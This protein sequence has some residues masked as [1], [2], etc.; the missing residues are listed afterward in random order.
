MF[1][2]TLLFTSI[3]ISTQAAA[4]NDQLQEVTIIGSAEDAMQ[5]PGSAHVVSE[6]ELEKFAYTDINRMVRQVPGVYLQ[7]EDGFGLRPNIGIRGS[8]SE[9]SDKITLLEDGVLMA[10]APYS[11]P[12][13][14]YFPTAG[15][16]HR[17]EILKGASI[18]RQGPATVGGVVNLISTPIPS[19][20]SAEINLETGDFSTHNLNASYGTRS[21]HWGMLLE[22]QQLQSDGFKKIDRSNQDSGF[23]VEDYLA[24]F[25]VNTAGDSSFYQQL[26][27]KI[28]YSEELSN[29]TYVGL[30]DR[31]FRDTSNRRYGLTA[32]DQMD[33]RHSSISARHLVQL[34]DQITLT[35][36][37]YQNR[38][39]RDW[40]KVDKIDGSSFGSLIDAA[41][42]GDVSA[43]SIL[44]GD[45]DAEISIK[46]NAREYTSQGL[47]SVAEWSVSSH[48]MELGI[49]Y[50]EDDVDRFQPSEV[51]QQ[52]SG[53]L[54]FDRITSPSS[55]NNRIEEA[56]ALAIHFMDTWQASAQLDVTMGLRHEDIDT[57]QLRYSDPQRSTRT[58]TANNSV[59]ETLWSL[60][61]TYDLTPNWQV[62]A[63]VHTGFAP[64]SA[65]SSDNVEPEKSQNY[66]AGFRYQSDAFNSSVI[67]FFSDYESTVLNCSQAFPCGQQSSGSQSLGQSEIAGV[68]LML[69]TRLYNSGS[70]Q[71]PLMV[72]F[73]HTDAEITD[74]ES[75]DSL[76]AGDVLR[77]VPENVLSTQVGINYGDSLSVYVNANYVSEMCHNNEC[78]RPGINDT[79]LETDETLIFDLVGHYNINDNTRLYIKID[80]I[81]DEQEIVARSPGGARPS[82]P[83]AASVGV[84][85]QF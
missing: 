33:T 70:V 71:V 82:K 6:A 80:N 7:E 12:A 29:E 57:R 34:N 19:Q 23:E 13:A 31:D 27:L 37:A 58:L 52:S 24:K 64:A 84:N 76:Q 53:N 4:S 10:P 8:G 17:I 74:A 60:G 72:S 43:Q 1:K 68:E 69:E 61:A 59:S 30:T 62:L 63:G 65:G 48:Q 36:T 49:R 18:L 46:H 75:N 40:F 14:Y 56:E 16:M 11:A 67:G 44:N 78:D 41:N 32:N 15:R 55:S 47:Q 2:R 21:A 25:T 54:V 3:L 73:T 81:L 26:D 79:L 50:H 28:Q 20:T 85:F 77:Y 39:K 35:T 66:E 9:R 83:R 22:T 45:T 42:I 5:L 38:F 51:F